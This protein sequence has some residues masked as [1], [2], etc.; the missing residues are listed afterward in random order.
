[1]IT[2]LLSL[3]EGIKINEHYTLPFG[4]ELV[5]K[6]MFADVAGPSYWF[7]FQTVNNNVVEPS[8]QSDSSKQQDINTA[9]VPL[10]EIS[11]YLTLLEGG[12]PEDKLECE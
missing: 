1:M 12:K 10:K 8:S 3:R 4:N 11:A 9:R 2:S 7:V 5:Q 6:S